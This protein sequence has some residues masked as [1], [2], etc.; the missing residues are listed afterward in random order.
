MLDNE[1]WISE[2]ANDQINTGTWLAKAE[3]ERIL[4]TRKSLGMDTALK[5][6]IF[7]YHLS[8]AKSEED[9]GKFGEQAKTGNLLRAWDFS[10]PK[11]A[12]QAL[13]NGYARRTINAYVP[14]FDDKAGYSLKA[15]Q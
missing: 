11:S 1:I 2:L 10:L 5:I 13:W 15:G 12:D 4:I 14:L 6:A 7:G 9:Q 8:F 3:R